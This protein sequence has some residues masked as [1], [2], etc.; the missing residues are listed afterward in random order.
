MKEILPFFKLSIRGIPVGFMGEIIDIIAIYLLG[1][2]TDLDI[3]YQVYLSQAIGLVA[4][5]FGYYIYTF[6]R[7][8]T[9]GITSAFIRFVIV[10]IISSI[11]CSE[12]IIKIIKDLNNKS[13]S[14]NSIYVNGK[15]TPLGN[16]IIKMLVDGIFYLIKMYIYKS[17]LTE[18][19]NQKR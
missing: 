5:F 17:I 6:Q 16:T 9:K 8:N 15:L 10:N 7:R 18:K 11:I 1:K 12:I 19:Q 4:T 13:F 2:H 14:D 3:V